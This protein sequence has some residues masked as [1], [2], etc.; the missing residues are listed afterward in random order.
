M[1][2]TPIRLVALDLDGTTLNDRKQITPRTRAA[3][4]AALEQG[5]VVVP[6]TGRTVTGISPQLLALPGVRYAITSNGARVQDLAAGQTLAAVNIPTELALKAH[7]LLRQ[8]DCTVDLFQDGQGYCTRHSLDNYTRLAPANLLPYLRSSRILVPD[9]RAVIAAQPDGVE[10]LTTLF[11]REDERQAAWAQMEALGLAAVS[12]LPRNMEL[13]A[14]GVNKGAGLLLLAQHLGI[15]PAQTMACGDGGNDIPM[16]R[17]AGIG[18]AMANAFEPVKAA[19]DL[20][21]ASNE[22]DGVAQAIERLVLG[23]C[24]H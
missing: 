3:L 2:H 20:I 17:A 4:L 10:K 21:T 6:A 23:R 15:D 16:L 18:V 24:E 11:A 7:D 8:Y 12:S 22:E 9:L 5:V 14:A 19:A 1:T 13:N